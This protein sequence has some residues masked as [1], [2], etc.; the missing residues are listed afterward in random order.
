MAN[1]PLAAGSPVAAGPAWPAPGD[2]PGGRPPEAVQLEAVQLEAERLPAE[3]RSPEAERRRAAERL[4][5]AARLPQVSLLRSRVRGFRWAA[6][7]AEAEARRTDRPARVPR[8]TRPH[9]RDRADPPAT[10]SNFGPGGER[11][12]AVAHRAEPAR[13]RSAAR[14]VK[15]RHQVQR[16]RPRIH[17]IQFP[18]S[19]RSRLHPDLRSGPM[20]GQHRLHLDFGERSPYRSLFGAPPKH[21]LSLRSAK[22]TVEHKRAFAHD[23]VT[24]IP[25]SYRAGI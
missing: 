16:G 18:G 19:T 2:T 3:E 24:P 17:R 4:P 7:R 1:N 15:A 5:A 9:S 20:P 21:V 6:A 25:F 12:P 13:T 22:G 8:S 14:R 10:H 23:C 11:P